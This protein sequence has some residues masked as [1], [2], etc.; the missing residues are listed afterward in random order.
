MGFNSAFKSLIR[1][2]KGLRLHCCI[3]C[4]IKHSARL[5]SF[6]RHAQDFSQGIVQMVISEPEYVAVLVQLRTTG[7]ILHIVQIGGTFM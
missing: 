6:I 1:H 2:L 7:D 4:T 3:S 5:H